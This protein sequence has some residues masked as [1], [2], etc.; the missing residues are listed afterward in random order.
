MIM[1]ERTY[2]HERGSFALRASFW[3][4]LLA[5]PMLTLRL[6]TLDP[7]A[8]QK[9]KPHDTRATLRRVNGRPPRGTFME[10][11]RNESVYEVSNAA[12][13]IPLWEST[14]RDDLGLWTTVWVLFGTSFVG[15]FIVASAIGLL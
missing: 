3:S 12:A 15:G 5:K 4:L 7:G 14:M 1:R 11:A 9:V 13:A 6:S 8:I 10:F 2:S